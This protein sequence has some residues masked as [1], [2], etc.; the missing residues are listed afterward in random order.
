MLMIP[1]KEEESKE[2]AILYSV[3]EKKVYNN[4]R[5]HIPRNYLY[6][7]MTEGVYSGAGQGWLARGVRNLSDEFNNFPKNDPS[8]RITLLNPFRSQRTSSIALPLLPLP[9]K[10]DLYKF[11]VVLSADPTLN[12]DNYVVILLCMRSMYS[13][14]LAFVTGGRKYWTR[15]VG[16]D[17]MITDAIFYKGRVYAIANRGTRSKVITFNGKGSSVQA[18]YTGQWLHDHDVGTAYLVESTEGDLLCVRRH[19][20]PKACST[21]DGGRLWGTEKFTVYKLTLN[22]RSGSVVSLVEV[23][24][25]GDNALFLGSNS[26]SMSVLASK[27]PGCQPNCIYYTNDLVR[28]N[29]W[30]HDDIVVPLDTG[31]FNMEDKTIAQLCPQIS[32]E[33][34]GSPL[35]ITPTFSGLSTDSS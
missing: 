9:E 14:E 10:K 2:A 5:F 35:W 32:M 18:S 13:S 33:E 21:T 12:P 23:K 29:W 19:A 17:W 27:H 6:R 34:H 16:D 28:L 22:N 25:I 15:P 24:S 3:S 8:L 30:L 7:T 26:Q 31:I 20:E 1:K 4:F 11:K